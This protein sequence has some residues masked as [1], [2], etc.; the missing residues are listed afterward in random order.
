MPNSAGNSLNNINDSDKNQDDDMHKK[1]VRKEFS[2]Q[3][4]DGNHADQK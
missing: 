1:A 2:V 3:R 4:T